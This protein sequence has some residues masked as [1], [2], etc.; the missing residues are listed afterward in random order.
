MVAS[1]STRPLPRTITVAELDRDPHSIFR[2]ERARVPFLMREDGVPFILRAHDVQTLMTDPRTRQLETESVALR[3]VES[4][5]LFRL[6]EESMLTSNGD[7]HRRRR[8]PMSRTFAF[9]VMRELRPRIR[10][11]AERLLDAQHALGGMDLLGDFATAIPARTIGDILGLP[12]R[13]IPTFTKLVYK[14]STVF[15]VSW[16]AA[17]V[18][19][20]QEA[21]SEL[22]DYSAGILDDRRRS[23]QDDFLTAYVQAADKEGELSASE[24]LIQLALVI[25]GGSDT[26]RAALVIQAALLLAYR[27]QWEAVCADPALVSGAVLESLRFEPA[28]GSVARVTLEDVDIDGHVVPARQYISL[29]TMSGLRDAEIYA[30]PDTF[31]I[32]RKD[33]PRWH[34][35]FG[36]GAHRCLG[37]ALAIAELEEGLAALSSRYSGL[38]LAGEPLRVS[39]HGGIRRVSNLQV[40]WKP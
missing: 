21:A 11:V 1:P 32:H 28:V 22:F 38:R 18:P 26:T 12:P 34:M 15:T 14:V 37:E 4:G 2:D 20:L 40:S 23:P 10:A 30:A 8:A 9:R 29:S 19:A 13:D 17:D 31:D 25:I 35:V 24:I 39:G 3:G 6:V 16:T 7:A 36:G 33:H 27:E 5:P